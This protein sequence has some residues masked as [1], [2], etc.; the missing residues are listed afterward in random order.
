MQAAAALLQHQ[1][2]VVHSSARTRACALLLTATCSATAIPRRWLARRSSLGRSGDSS[3]TT[4]TGS[5]SPSSSGIAAATAAGSSASNAV[6]LQDERGRV[7]VLVLSGPTAVGKTQLSLRLAKELNG[8]VISA[9]SMQVFQGLDIGTDKLAPAKQQGIPHHLMSILPFDGNTF[10]AGE[11]AEQARALIRDVH[12]RGR[13]PIVVGGTMFWLSM[14]VNRPPGTP[15]TDKAL[16]AEI[17]AEVKALSGWDEAL[18][19]LAKVDPEYAARLNRN[20]WYRLTRGLSIIRMSG[21]KVSSFRFERSDASAADSEFDFRRVYLTLPRMDLFE[22][23]DERCETILHSGIIEETV[24]LVAKGFHKDMHCAKALGYKEAL[25]YL[26]QS[27]FKPRNRSVQSR[28]RAL[29]QFLLSFQAASRQYA[30]KQVTWFRK[31]PGY[32]WIVRQPGQTDEELSRAVVDYFVSSGAERERADML[33]AAE[34]VTAAADADR[35]DVSLHRDDL[36]S[37][38]PDLKIFTTLP[39]WDEKIHTIRRSIETQL[40]QISLLEDRGRSLA[41]SVIAAA[42]AAELLRSEG[43]DGD[44]GAE[45]ADEGRGFK[46]RSSGGRKTKAG[47]FLRGDV[48]TEDGDDDDGFGAGNSRTSI[49]GGSGGMSSSSSSSSLHR[50]GSGK[51]PASSGPLRRAPRPLRMRDA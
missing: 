27:W 49:S 41:P 17:L 14:L 30:R 19:V 12:A 47:S 10:S 6:P 44:N 8:E 9:D 5:S 38:M 34:A 2:L 32:R 36:H 29:S 39:V 21:K 50:R 28:R 4:N 46:G 37:Y 1:L 26:E 23:I 43:D 7:R 18:Q 48:S 40:P 33:A 42:E 15:P 13:V 25:E 11:F 3:S 31:Q 20:D 45:A 22:R 51:T 35:S 24:G 16:E